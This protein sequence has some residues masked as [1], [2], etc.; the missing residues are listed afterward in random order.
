VKFYWQENS[1]RLIK[2]PHS[3]PANSRC[4]V[5]HSPSGSGAKQ[6]P[7]CYILFTI[8]ASSRIVIRILQ[9]FHANSAG[10]VI[11]GL[12]ECC[13]VL[14]FFAA[15]QSTLLRL[16]LARLLVI[17]EPVNSSDC[18]TLLV[19]FSCSVFRMADVKSLIVS[20]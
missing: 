9:A 3:D 5:C 12:C 4:V 8:F 16:L 17:I 1:I 2:S 11:F 18:T 14:I 6:N 20:M 19:F 7:L 13:R 10:C 15:R